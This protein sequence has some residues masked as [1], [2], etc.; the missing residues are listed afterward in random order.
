VTVA[1]L[2]AA[3]WTLRAL[4]RVRRQLRDGHLH[5]VRVPP[6]PRLSPTA[7]RGVEG[8]LRRRR[9]SC[10]ERALLLQQWHAAHGRSLDVVVGVTA[11]RDFRAHAW[12][13]DEPTPVSP[14]FDE[15][16]R[17]SP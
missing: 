14:V 2:R 15:L 11:P 9:N 12:L 16:F 10:L 7:V 8:V 3:G 13:E 4:G 1:E 6:P 17:L 5:D